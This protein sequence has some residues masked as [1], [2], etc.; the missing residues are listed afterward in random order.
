MKTRT[1]FAQILY[2]PRPPCGLRLA[3]SL[4]PPRIGTY[5]PPAQYLA[6][7]TT[8]SQ[9]DDCSPTALLMTARRAKETK[10]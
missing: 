4:I 9:R 7:S 3:S 10:T 5:T 2:L 1:K 6:R 8:Q